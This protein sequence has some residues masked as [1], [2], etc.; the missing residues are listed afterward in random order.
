M[1]TAS[2]RD[3]WAFIREKY[4]SS[5]TNRSSLSIIESSAFCLALDDEP[6]ETTDVDSLNKFAKAMLHGKGYD[7]WFDKSFCLVVAS[8]GIS[9]SSVEHSWYELM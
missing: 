4:F 6:F 7:R 8:N 9:G 5:G 1:F 3:L 2:E